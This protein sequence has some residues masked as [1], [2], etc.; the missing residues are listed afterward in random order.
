MSWEVAS[1]TSRFEEAYEWFRGRV[2][3]TRK[4]YDELDDSARAKAFWISG[5]IELDAI[6][7]VFDDIAASIDK[8]T[9]LQEF[10]KSIRDKLGARLGI[11]GFHLETVYRN[12]T[13]QAYNAGRWYQMTEPETARFRPFMM[14]DSIL[15]SRTTDVCA[16]LNGTIRPV[17]DSFWLTHCP[18]LHHR[19]RSSL[20]SLRRTEAERRGVTTQLPDVEVP[21][22]FGLAPPLR[23]ADIHKVDKKD[24]DPR[25]KE[26]ADARELRMLAELEA[27][28]DNARAKRTKQDPK[29]WLDSAYRDQYGEDAGRA[30]A[31]GR[32]MEERGQDASLGE[33][34][35]Q[36]QELTDDLGIG[37][38]V[39]S[40]PLF[41]RLRTAAEDGYIPRE[42]KTLREVSDAL[43]KSVD[44]DRELKQLL[45]EVRALAALIGHRASIEQ[46]GTAVRM[47]VPRL[48]PDM[49]REVKSAAFDMVERVG[50][51]WSLLGDKSLV[52][53]DKRKG[54][55]IQW[56]KARA[57]FDHALRIVF[58]S[59]HVHDGK[60]FDYGF[61]TI[62]HEMGHGIEHLNDR[63]RRAA[64]EFFVRRTAGEQARKLR[65]LTGDERYKDHEVAKKDRFHSAY[66]GKEYIDRAGNRY[67]TEVSSMGL[68]ELHRN[69]ANLVDK[70]E[71]LFW[72]SLGQLAG[73]AVR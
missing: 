20:R 32:A 28:N 46:A 25:V 54:F 29:H 16:K 37:L 58:T 51:F 64:E 73:E 39:H 18:Q 70:D 5:A 59:W 67:A 6:R 60:A 12:A 35:R 57:Y 24:L 41:A 63:A 33:A 43:S 69:A 53:A 48:S 62:V 49:P 14:Y 19:C 71:E 10:K 36:Y 21:Q 47:A 11:D 13:Q 45:N 52:L 34:K 56:S 44:K 15:D 72:F 23:G 1:D 65:D 50:K 4:Q 42:A 2:P 40:T 30:V 27:A 68:E 3:Y 55:V 9:S 22:G 8:G 66:V 31:W 17:G 38:S 61:S 26:A 7:T